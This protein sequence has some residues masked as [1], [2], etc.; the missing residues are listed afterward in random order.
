[1]WS[2]FASVISNKSPNVL[3]LDNTSLS[4]MK[5]QQC[6]ICAEYLVKINGFAL[7]SFFVLD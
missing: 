2:V 5:G 1:M 4:Y 7:S 3:E 6:L